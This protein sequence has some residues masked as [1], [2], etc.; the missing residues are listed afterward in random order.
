MQALTE[1]PTLRSVELL[2][3]ARQAGYTGGKSAVYA[4]GA[5][6]ADPRRDAAGPLRRPPGRILATRF[7]RSARALSG[8]DGGGRALLRLALEILALGRG[9]A[10]APTSR[11]RAWCARSSITSPAFG[12]IPLGGGLR[13][14][15]DGG[16]EVG[17]RWRRH[18]VE[19]RPLPAWRWISGSGW[20]CAG[21]IARKRKAASRIWS[22]G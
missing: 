17:P 6:A 12:G 13:S 11:S 15:E 10:G 20:K 8:R 19:C 3:R 1:E 2:H 16:A 21:R 5:D 18:R 9:D 22:G 4:L 7:R 14:A